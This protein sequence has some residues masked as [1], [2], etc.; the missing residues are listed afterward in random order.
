MRGRAP[1]TPPLTLHIPPTTPPPPSNPN[2]QPPCVHGAACFGLGPRPKHTLT[3]GPS[4]TTAVSAQQARPA[5]ILLSAP[6]NMELPAATSMVLPPRMA[7]F[8]SCPAVTSRGPAPSQVS[9]TN[10]ATHGPSPWYVWNW[11]GAMTGRGASESIP[12]IFYLLR[13]LSR[14]SC[15][16][17]FPAP[18]CMRPGRRFVRN[19]KPEAMEER[20]PRSE[21]G[22]GMPRATAAA[23]ST[24]TFSDKRHLTGAV[25]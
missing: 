19:F 11:S 22:T 13:T 6:P 21:V 16:C 20:P 5:V 18:S 17:G 7:S 23:A 25:S 24:A 4:A 12:S 1:I 8:P 14:R 15:A 9:G 3:L 10:P 2:T